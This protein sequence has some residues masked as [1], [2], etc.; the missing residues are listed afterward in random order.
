[1]IRRYF[2]DTDEIVRGQRRMCAVHR[3]FLDRL[4]I[5]CGI[6]ALNLDI[7]IYVDRRY[8]RQFMTLVVQREKD[9]I[10][11]R[12]PNE[13]SQRIG[14]LYLGV[15]RRHIGQH[16]QSGM[17]LPPDF[18]KETPEDLPAIAVFIESYERLAAEAAVRAYKNEGISIAEK[19][20]AKLKDEGVTFADSLSEVHILVAVATKADRAA[21]DED[22]P[23]KRRILDKIV[24]VYRRGD[25][26]SPIIDT[27]LTVT[28]T[29]SEDLNDEPMEY[30]R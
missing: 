16:A 21:L 12:A 7:D 29:S 3:D 17:P 8:E 5:E 1:M 11:G 20:T 30:W 2:R 26:N 27:T 14:D 15:L 18:P 28:I 10:P 6:D 24:E 25:S 19:I 22:P 9:A 23:R 4:K 13:T